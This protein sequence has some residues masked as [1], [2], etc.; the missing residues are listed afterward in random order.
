MR[1]GIVAL[2]FRCRALSEPLPETD[3]SMAIA[4]H[5]ISAVRDLMPPAYAARL[6]DALDGDSHVRVHDGVELLD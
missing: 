3:E 1:R 5:D 2:V 6:L 4:W